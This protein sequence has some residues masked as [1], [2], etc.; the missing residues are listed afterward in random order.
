MYIYGMRNGKM[1]YEMDIK[2]VNLFTVVIPI[3]LVLVLLL[4]G[5]LFSNNEIRVFFPFIPGI[6]II[7]ISCLYE[8][9]D[10]DNGTEGLRIILRKICKSSSVMSVFLIFFFLCSIPFF[11]YFTYYFFVN[12]VTVGFSS[13]FSSCQLSRH[14]F[15]NGFTD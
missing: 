12:G 8:E 3:I 13:F 9:R 6:Y 14:F 2:R 10:E 1:T 11:D 5:I 15:E 7:L 4:L